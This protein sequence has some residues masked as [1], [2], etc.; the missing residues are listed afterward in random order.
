[1]SPE[2]LRLLSDL[3]RQVTLNAAGDDFEEAAALVI[4]AKRELAEALA[5]TEAGSS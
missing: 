1:M 4:K 2:V 3:L 5:A